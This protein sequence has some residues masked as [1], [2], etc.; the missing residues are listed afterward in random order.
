[1]FAEEIS[2]LILIMQV[3]IVLGLIYSFAAKSIKPIPYLIQIILVRKII[4]LH[5]FKKSEAQT[6]NYEA[7]NQAKNM[8]ASILIVMQTL[9]M[10]F[11]IKSK[12]LRWVNVLFYLNF[13]FV[14]MILS[15]GKLDEMTN[16]DLGYLIP[17]QVMLNFFVIV[18]FGVFTEIMDVLKSETEKNQEYSTY[19]TMFNSLQE[20]IAILKEKDEDE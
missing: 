17:A 7:L 12:V 3:A 5:N 2:I 1:M 11:I 8:T 4:N 6:L 19:K 20:G 18:T 10:C 16:N 9:F 14:S 13:F 15:Y